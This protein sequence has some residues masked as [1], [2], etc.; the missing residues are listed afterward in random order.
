MLIHEFWN[1]DLDKVPWESPLII[2]DS[3]CAMCM[4]NNGMYDKHDLTTRMKYIMVI[5][6]N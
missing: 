4:A 2:L 6:D 3:N 5:L 1:K